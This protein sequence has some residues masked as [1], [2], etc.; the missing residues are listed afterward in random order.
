MTLYRVESLPTY[1]VLKRPIQIQPEAKYFIVTENQ[2]YYA[3]LEETHIRHCEHGI[4]TICDATFPL[5][6]KRVPTCA[7]V[8]YFGQNAEVYRY[9]KRQILFPNFEP[10]WIYAKSTIAFWVYSLPSPTKVTKTCKNKDNPTKDLM[11]SGAGILREDIHCQY[12]AEDFIL[13][14]VT[15]SFSNVTLTT[16]RVITK[17]LPQLIS[18]VERQQLREHE[19]SGIVITTPSSR[20]SPA[21]C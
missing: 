15:D 20:Q 11:L 17:D 9:G 10:V 12:Y 18:P 7:S 4:I 5:I 16:G 19:H 3:L 1:L 14:P 8:L 2:Q 13:L 6:H 21:L